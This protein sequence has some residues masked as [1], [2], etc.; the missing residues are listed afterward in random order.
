VRS[1][2]GSIS[3][4]APSVVLVEGETTNT[5]VWLVRGDQVIAEAR[6]VV[7]AR[8]TARDG[9][10]HRLEAALHALIAGVRREGQELP[11]PCRPS[12]VVAAGMLTSSL[13]LREVEHVAAPA[14]VKELAARMERHTFRPITDLPVLLVPG[15]RSGPLRCER[16][17]VGSTDVIRGEEIIALGLHLLGWLPAGGIVLSLGA[18]W[19]AIHVDRGGQITSSITSLGGEL[20]D[21]VTCQTVL[22]GSLP[23][24]WPEEVD[25]AWVDAGVHESQR[26][27]LGRALFCVRLLE[28]RVTSS[29]EERLAFLL[30]AAIGN[31]MDTLLAR[32][33]FRPGTRVLVT[34][35]PALAHAFAQQ[36]RGT[37]VDAVPV[38]DTQVAHAVRV[39]MLEVLA[40][41][42]FGQTR[43]SR[44]T[45]TRRPT[46]GISATSPPEVSSTLIRAAAASANGRAN[47][48]DAG[49]TP[50][51]APTRTST[52][53][54]RR[55]RTS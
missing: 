2:G 1:R 5:R 43:S 29:P 30:G 50:S 52:S 39:S 9:S 46:V 27:G 45:R 37:S 16:D 20:I 36:L 42:A 15:V 35:H 24:Q 7:G 53:R 19:K 17:A 41:S 38:S 26:S 4:D 33:F 32:R 55:P 40:H 21:V 6:T 12:V 10:P 48:S 3:N 23:R 22:A 14:G 34:G 54:R 49:A 47:R 51:E 13:G 28:Q 18:H 31:G 44:R 11:V 8:D 25:P